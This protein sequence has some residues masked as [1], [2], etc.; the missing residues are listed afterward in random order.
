MKAIYITE[1]KRWKAMGELEGFDPYEC[2]DYSIDL[3]GGNS[4]NWEY[5]GDIP[6]KE[7]EAQKFMKNYLETPEG[8]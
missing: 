2:K 5:I 1:W 7:T 8:K 3:G 6:E 4:V